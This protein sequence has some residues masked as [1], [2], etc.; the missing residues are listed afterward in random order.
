MARCNLALE[1]VPEE[2]P[3]ARTAL[4]EAGVPFVPFEME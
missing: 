2:L 1:V 3:D 4:R